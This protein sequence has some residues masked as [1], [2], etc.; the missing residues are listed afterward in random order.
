LIARKCGENDVRIAPL[1]AALL[2]VGCQTTGEV[3]KDTDGNVYPPQCR[4]DLSYVMPKVFV[5]YVPSNEMP[6][7][8]GIRPV[9]MTYYGSSVSLIM[10]STDQTEAEKA[11]T[12]R[13]E[14]CHVIA[15]KW[16]PV[17]QGRLQ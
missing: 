2:L 4:G 5:R 6:L 17:S 9:G 15:G 13:H 16:H 12:L 3:Y 11:D 8:A 7:V 14:L 1:F 10:I